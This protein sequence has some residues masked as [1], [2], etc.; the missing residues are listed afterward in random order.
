MNAPT[1]QQFGTPTGLWSSLTGNAGLGTPWT[2]TLPVPLAGALSGALNVTDPTHATPGPGGSTPAPGT[3]AAPVTPP[4]STG[5]GT[6]SWYNPVMDWLHPLDSLNAGAQ[7]LLVR[8]TLLAV[9]GSLLYLG[10]KTLSE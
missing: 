8:V 1:L 9:G 10:F 5:N 4:D 7:S 2:P 3:T 6:P